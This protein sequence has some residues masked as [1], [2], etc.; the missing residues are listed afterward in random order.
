MSAIPLQ[1]YAYHQSYGTTNLQ[2]YGVGEMS[3]V[4]AV[5]LNRTTYTKTWKL[6]DWYINPEKI[7]TQ[8]IIERWWLKQKEV[9]RIWPI[10]KSHDKDRRNQK[11]HAKS[12][13]VI[14]PLFAK[15]YQ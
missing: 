10:V 6:A 7:S 1:L 11:A 2:V 4:I 13:G 3:W 5:P 8:L 15:S 9:L 14:T 12:M